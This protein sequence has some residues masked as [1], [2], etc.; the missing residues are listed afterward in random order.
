[1]A[2][3]VSTKMALILLCVLLSAIILAIDTLAPLGVAGGVPYVAVVL[4]TLW[5][6]GR[7]YTL[8]FSVVCTVL[9]MIG[10]FG[11][12]PG[13]V[14]WKILCNRFLAVFVIW[15][16]AILSIQRKN[17]ENT[18]RNHR[19]HLTEMVEQRTLEI[20]K[21]NE[22]LRG[23]IQ[24]T[25]LA[26]NKLQEKKARIKAILDTAADAIICID[27]Q[28]IVCSI[29]PATEKMFGYT[30]KEL[31]GKSLSM[32]M[33]SPNRKEVGEYIKKYLETGESKNHRFLPGIFG[34]A[35]R[36]RHFSR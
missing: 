1:M 27:E 12:P 18:L 24:Q 17:V 36:R 20:K 35:Q 32:I 5:L 22:Q 31:L 30:E 11:S 25:I 4:L 33:P 21:I 16:T 23:E 14:L 7:K 19:D 8:I 10:F 28:G 9:T 6:P 26:K 15:T 29:N 2:L 34:N 13:G 3:K